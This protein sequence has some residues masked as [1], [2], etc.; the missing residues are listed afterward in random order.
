M[1]I[2]DILAETDDIASAENKQQAVYDAIKAAMMRGEFPEGT[3]MVERKLCER[4]GV[5]RSP[6]RE[7]LKRFVREGLMDFTTG[8]RVI[9]PYVTIEEIMDVYDVLELIEPYIARRFMKYATPEQVTALGKCLDDMSAALAKGDMQ[10]LVWG[11]LEFHTSLLYGSGLHRN[12][13]EL[14]SMCAQ[15]IRIMSTLVPDNRDRAEL[16]DAQHRRI[17]DAIL[18]KDG[19]ELERAVKAHIASVRATYIELFARRERK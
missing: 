3:I 12:R 8:N 6:V 9:I 13:A 17:Y 16:S 14:G 10:P 7:A 18:A 2:P 4:F 11:D 5:S 19:D 15:R 1:K